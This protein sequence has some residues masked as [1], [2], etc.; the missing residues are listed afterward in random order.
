MKQGVSRH[1]DGSWLRN[2]PGSRRKTEASGIM[3]AL[4]D[5]ILAR[6]HTARILAKSGASLRGI[7]LYPI[8][9]RLPNPRNQVDLKIGL[10][11]TCPLSEPISLMFE[12]IWVKR[13]YAP[14]EFKISAGDTVVDI[15]ANLGVFSVWAAT[16]APGVRVIALEP[17]PRMFHFLE[18]NL[19]RNGLTQVTAIQ[20]ACGGHRGT[21]VLY[22]RGF[23]GGNSLYSRD[24]VGSVFH[25][26]AEVEII[27]LDDIF[28]RHAVEVCSLL[29]LSC[30][31]AE[32]D[33][34]FNAS[35]NTLRRIEN[36]SMEY[37]LGLNDHSV[38]D[39]VG[40]LEQRGFQVMHT[41]PYDEECGYLY[42]SRRA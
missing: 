30:V 7:I 31:G 34:L 24:L 22:S 2:Q 19:S 26:L 42:G 1:S 10:S 4:G 33:I 35:E 23:E 18:Q 32:Y 6:Y 17:S 40:F 28:M 21:G 15:G 11:I 13:C 14:G 29:K 20:A 27:T 37:H 8:R 16:R 41:P 12:D 5:A 38:H 3:S 9:H 36:I 25:P 39:M